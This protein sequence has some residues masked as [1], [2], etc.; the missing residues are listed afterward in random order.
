M[1]TLTKKYI[2]AKVVAL[3]GTETKVAISLKCLDE[4]TREHQNITSN[5]AILANL[6]KANSSLTFEKMTGGR[7]KLG[8]KRTG[9]F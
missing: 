1:Y 4:E 3:L 8:T 5:M 7:K 6:K 9:R 2:Q